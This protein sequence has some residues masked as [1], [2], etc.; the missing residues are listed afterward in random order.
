M[1]HL[2]G[3]FCQL[4][5]RCRRSVNSAVILPEIFR[6][7]VIWWQGAVDKWPVK[8]IQLWNHE[9]FARRRRLEGLKEN[10]LPTP[11][12][13]VEAIFTGASGLFGWG[14]STG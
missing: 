11:G 4:R 12:S 7:D 5:R 14:A 1:A 10:V 2:P 9:R 8:S 6:D 13:A 3:G